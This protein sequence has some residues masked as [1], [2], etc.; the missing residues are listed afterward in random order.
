MKEPIILIILDGFGYRHSH[1]FN[2][3]AQANTPNLHTWLDHY[4]HT[5]LQ[6]AGTA[7]GLL[8]GCVGNSEVGHETIGA[9]RVVP[10]PVAIIHEA[11]QAKKLARNKTLL[12]AFD[13]L[14]TLHK[15]LH[16]IGLL[17]DA[18]VHSH[19]ELLYRLIDIALNHHVPRIYI[20][21]ILDGRDVPPQSA[22]QYLQ[23]LSDYIR[24]QQTVCIGSIQGR[25][26]AMDRDNNWDRTQQSIEMLT[27][28]QH[29]RFTTWQQA[30]DYWYKQ[31]VTDEFIPPTCLDANAIIKPQ[32]G[33]IF[34]NFRAD[35]ARQLTDLLLQKKD[36]LPLS[37]FITP[38]SYAEDIPTI[39][40]FTKKPI[41]NTLTDI[42]HVH[43][44]RVFV[45]AETEKYAP[46]TYF[47][48]VGRSEAYN[49][50]TQVLIPSLK[51]QSYATTPEMSAPAITQ[52][53]LD[54]LKHNPADFYLIN[55]ANA[56]MVAHSGNMQAT[57]HAIEC[58]DVQ[59]G[60]LYKQLIDVMHGTL[61]ITADHGNAED[62][63]DITTN[64][65]KTAHTTNVVPFLII[66]KNLRDNK[67]PLKLVSL[68]DIAPYILSLMHLPIP[69]EMHQLP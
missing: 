4:P 46:V 27:T 64:Q 10:Q 5:L 11:L 50:E 37:F 8:K 40:L 23:Q 69:Q 61:I 38:F 41:H 55:Y 20:H 2:A 25:Y 15:D 14:A 6:A 24:H 59:L 51:R 30:L 39:A 43:H 68:A 47:F 65:P 26:Y 19:Q 12:E 7:V 53:V 28:Q 44:K 36:R 56:D 3:I 22:Q 42:L 31:H 52:R 62:M 29:I 45:I 49:N 54:S 33:I 34:F 1:M 66:N 9:G 57:V 67:Q 16:I 35:R 32:D 48:N 58:L 21:P 17:S 18:G 13:Q 60:M 63:F